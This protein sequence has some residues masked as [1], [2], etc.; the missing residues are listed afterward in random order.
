M[1]L[2]THASLRDFHDRN[3]PHPRRPVLCRASHRALPMKILTYNVFVAPLVRLCP[4]ANIENIAKLI[5]SED[6]DIVC[7]Q[8][9]RAPSARRLD[10]MHT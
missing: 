7:I 2:I 8:G 3:L 9:Q 10:F 6:P 5:D 1:G 4:S